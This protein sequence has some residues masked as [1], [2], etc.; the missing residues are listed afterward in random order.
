MKVTR[1]MQRR[2][3][4]LARRAALVGS[5]TLIAGIDLAKR[6]SVVVFIRAK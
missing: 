6:E 1:G 2:T 4:K 3:A 5:D